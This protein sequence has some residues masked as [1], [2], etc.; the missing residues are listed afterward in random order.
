MDLIKAES[1]RRAGKDQRRR[2]EKRE[3]TAQKNAPFL[4]S[5]PLLSFKTANLSNAEKQ[6]AFDICAEKWYFLEKEI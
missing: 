2:L 4:L 1:E 5:S 6:R 3:F